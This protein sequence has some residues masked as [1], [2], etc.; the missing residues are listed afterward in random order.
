MA[1]VILVD[2]GH[3]RGLQ[4]Q[5]QRCLAGTGP[6]V[7]VANPSAAVVTAEACLA[8]GVPACLVADARGSHGLRWIGPLAR[9]GVYVIV[10]AGTAAEGRLG[11]DVGAHEV[12]PRPMH[13]PKAGVLVADALSRWRREG[14]ALIC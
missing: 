8:Q 1:Q 13:L 5:L 3:G 7:V 12:V 4:A 10:L 9:S 11:L 6:Q 2:D 14:L